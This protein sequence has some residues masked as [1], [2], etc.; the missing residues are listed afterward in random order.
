MSV[1]KSGIPLTEHASSLLKI[2]DALKQIQ[3]EDYDWLF[4]TLQKNFE[5]IAGILLSS[6]PEQIKALRAC[7]QLRKTR[8]SLANLISLWSTKDV[9]N[10]K[11]EEWLNEQSSEYTEKIDILPGKNKTLLLLD[12]INNATHKIT[13]DLENNHGAETVTFRTPKSI[14]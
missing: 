8:L 4:I 2:S 6:R 13:T 12:Q 7:D 14:F 5:A 9:S 11:D 3:A 10:K 1:E